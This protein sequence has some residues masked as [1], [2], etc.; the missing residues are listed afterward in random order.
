MSTKNDEENYKN[1]GTIQDINDDG[2]KRGI[3]PW[4]PLILALVYTFSPID[5]VP[6]F[7]PVAGWAE[8][9]LFLIVGSLN[10]I[11][12]SVLGVNTHLGKIVKLA[13]WIILI[14]GIIGVLIIVLL[15]VAI[16]RVIKN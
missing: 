1:N 12:K 10:G 5:L 7:I 14:L 6:D 4:I 13:K 9:A 15:A 16:Y 3:M 2:K 8:D 11:E